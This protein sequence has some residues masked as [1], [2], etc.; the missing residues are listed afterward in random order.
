MLSIA[1]QQH[2]ALNV[3]LLPGLLHVVLWTQGTGVQMLVIWLL[4]FP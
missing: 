2:E 4:L 3:H 1:F